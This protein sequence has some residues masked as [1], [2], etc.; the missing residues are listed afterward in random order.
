MHL[1]NFSKLDKEGGEFILGVILISKIIQADIEADFVVD[2]K[3]E[4]GECLVY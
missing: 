4:E 1:F 3:A 2:I